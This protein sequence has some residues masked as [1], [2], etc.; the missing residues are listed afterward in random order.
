MKKTLIGKCVIDHLTNGEIDQTHEQT[1]KNKQKII[2]KNKPKNKQTNKQ[3]NRRNR[4]LWQMC[5]FSMFIFFR[6]V[7]TYNLAMH[8]AGNIFCYNE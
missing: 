4:D 5:Q 8:A 7:I 1:S 2:K 3:P 6:S